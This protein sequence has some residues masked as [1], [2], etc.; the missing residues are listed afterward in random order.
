MTQTFQQLLGQ[1]ETGIRGYMVSWG[2]ITYSY[3]EYRK[4]RVQFVAVISTVSV[5]DREPSEG[6]VNTMVGGEIYVPKIPSFKV[7]DLAKAISSVSKI[8]IIGIKP[9][10]KIHE[11]LC[12]VD[13]SGNLYENKNHYTMYSTTIGP[14]KKLGKKV[15]VSLK[16]KS[17]INLVE[18]FLNKID[19]NCIKLQYTT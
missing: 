1:D 19:F 2:Q 3:A 17:Q 13:E 9:G 15:G 14:T 11:T 6:E 16:P 4:E 8:K 10:E 18:D 12:S 5:G 7:T